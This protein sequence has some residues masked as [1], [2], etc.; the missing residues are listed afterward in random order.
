MTKEGKAKKQAYIVDYQRRVY[1]N[2]SFKVRTIEDNDIIEILKNV[3]NK[4]EYIKKLIRDD[5]GRS[6]E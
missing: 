3:S 2:I 6:A 1:T 5:A 4:S